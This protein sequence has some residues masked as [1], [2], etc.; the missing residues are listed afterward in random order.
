MTI[1]V[2]SAAMINA[3]I[4]AGSPE[5]MAEMSRHEL[6]APHL[7]DLEVL[8]VLRKLVFRGV[9]SETDADDAH[10]LY[11]DMN[12]TRYA[13]DGMAKRIWSLR[14]TLNCYDAAYVVLAEVL[15]VPLVTC[16]AKMAV[17]AKKHEATIQVFYPC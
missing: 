12:V 1:V 16:D 10:D 3:L 11:A 9:L 2:D 15:Q 6:V 7:L 14:A 4:D 5:L 13:S 17:A 8:S